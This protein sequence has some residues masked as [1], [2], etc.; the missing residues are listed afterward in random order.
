MGLFLILIL[1]FNYFTITYTNTFLSPLF[2][3]IP[4]VAVNLCPGEFILET[5]KPN[6]SVATSVEPRTGI[7]EDHTRE[8]DCERLRQDCDSSTEKYQ[9][10][11]N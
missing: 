3:D 4:C 2:A 9:I 5:S 11:L 1:C 8:I 7:N 6:L 10:S